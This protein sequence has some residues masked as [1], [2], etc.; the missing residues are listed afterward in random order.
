MGVEF[1]E[2]PREVQDAVEQ[3]MAR[4]HTKQYRVTINGEEKILSLQNINYLLINHKIS[5][6]HL[7]ADVRKVLDEDTKYTIEMS[8]DDWWNEYHKEK[9]E[10]ASKQN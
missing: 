3:E 7:S 5:P 9:Y 8:L 1:S 4:R 10:N 2:L 6:D